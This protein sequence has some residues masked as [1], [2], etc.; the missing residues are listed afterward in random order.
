VVKVFKSGREKV[1]YN[2]YSGRPSTSK[3]DGNVSRV[4]DLFNTDRRMSV[5]MMAETQ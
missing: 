4:G 1:E 5:W 3:S 2:P